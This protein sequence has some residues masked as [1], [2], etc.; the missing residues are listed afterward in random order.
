MSKEKLI[1]EASKE[2]IEEWKKKHGEMYR[3]SIVD[4]EENAHVCYLKK[5]S[6]KS[7][8]Y[9][10]VGSKSNPIKFNEILLKECFVGGDEE[11]MKDDDL[12]LSAGGQLAELIQI[13]EAELVKL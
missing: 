2:Q 7:I 4:S 11:I 5:P 6:R 3:L 8:G 10:S 9:A 12:F 1:G 13:R